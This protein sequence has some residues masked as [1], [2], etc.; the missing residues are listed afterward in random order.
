MP[1]SSRSPRRMIT[2]GPVQK[3][4]APAVC[5][6]RGC[7]HTAGA[8]APCPAQ[9][10]DVERRS[11]PVAGFSAN[12]NYF[13]PS[14]KRAQLNSSGYR[15][16]ASCVNCPARPDEGEQ[17]DESGERDAPLP[18]VAGVADRLHRVRDG[19]HAAPGHRAPAAQA[20]PTVAAESGPAIAEACVACKRGPGREVLKDDLWHASCPA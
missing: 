13:P 8:T 10:Q 3:L 15:S 20:A 19:H 14:F 4:H 9:Q 12:S 1:H 16:S 11:A 18:G 5:V 6:R 2:P 7:T 17:P